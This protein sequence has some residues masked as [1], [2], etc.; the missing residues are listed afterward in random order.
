MFA[1]LA[2]GLPLLLLS[3]VLV[4]VATA[5]LFRPAR[6]L[7]RHRATAARKRVLHGQVDDWLAS[8][9]GTAPGTMPGTAEGLTGAAAT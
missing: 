1:G 6:G 7:R 5:V 3:L 9:P 4:V 2:L 8:A